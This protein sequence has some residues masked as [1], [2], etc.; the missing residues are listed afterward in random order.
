[1][2]GKTCE[3]A[4]WLAICTITGDMVNQWACGWPSIGDFLALT[5]TTAQ[6]ETVT[7]AKLKRRAEALTNHGATLH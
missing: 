6:Q 3:H 1:M 4:Q 7:H 5:G 2:S